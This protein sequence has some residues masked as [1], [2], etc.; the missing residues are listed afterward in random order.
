MNN[1]TFRFPG[2]TALI[3]GA[4][5][6]IGR[7][8]ALGFA[9]A[10]AA[11]LATGRDKGELASLEAE[12]RDKGGSCVTISADLSDR[13]ETLSMARRFCEGPSLP[14]ILI[15]NAGVSFPETIIE[16]DPDHWD[17]TIAVNLRAPALVTGVVAKAMMDRGG[18]TPGCIVNVG[19]QAGVAALT[20][21][22]AYC[23]SK[24]G[25][26]GLTKVMALE[27][28]PHGIRA[29]AVAPTVTLT[30]MGEQVW[31]DPGKGDPMKAKIP[32]GTFA[33]P[34]DIVHAVMFLASEEARMINGE[35]LLIDGG[36][37]AQ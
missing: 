16:L 14:D 8:L 9:T 17:R 24:F 30:P 5:K 32:L 35:V 37:T 33:Y 27:L 13:E 21:H 31:G 4:T 3:T 2:R 10:G 20:E 34:V 19:S 26:H 6:G 23:A 25:L 22:A 1:V 11:I 12:I 28:G 18:K 7:E 36:Y 29:N 15:N